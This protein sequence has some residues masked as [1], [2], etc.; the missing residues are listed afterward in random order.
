MSGEKRDAARQLF[1]MRRRLEE[2]SEEMSLAITIE[3][4]LSARLDGAVADLRRIQ[5]GLEADES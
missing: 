5:R 1:Q 2:I 4:D 3:Y